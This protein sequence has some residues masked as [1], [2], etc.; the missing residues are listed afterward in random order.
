MIG[1]GKKKGDWIDFPYV[2]KHI[3]EELKKFFPE[4]NIYSFYVC[5]SDLFRYA[6]H[7]GKN[8]VGIKRIN[9]NNRLNKEYEKNNIFLF[10]NNEENFDTNST[11]IRKQLIYIDNYN[12][13]KE[14]NFNILN[15]NKNKYENIMNDLNKKIYSS[16]LKIAIENINKMK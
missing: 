2:K 13:K 4:E 11:D 12:K 1:K 9:D 7:M 10:E 15:D 5:G 14:E 6:I 8:V 16:V 3:D